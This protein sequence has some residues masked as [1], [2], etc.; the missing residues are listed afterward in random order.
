[1]SQGQNGPG[2]SKNGEKSERPNQKKP[3]FFTLPV[4]NC[5]LPTGSTTITTKGQKGLFS[6]PAQAAPATNRFRLFLPKSKYRKAEALR[7]KKKKK[8][9]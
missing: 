9:N 2:E 4:L 6:S 3:A 5:T 1:V 7:S 8:K